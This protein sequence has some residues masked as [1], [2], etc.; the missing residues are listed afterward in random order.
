[1]PDEQPNFDVIWPSNEVMPLTSGQIKAL[2]KDADSWVNFLAM[3]L[4]KRS[5]AAMRIYEPG[6]KE[7]EIIKVIRRGRKAPPYASLV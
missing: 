7:P 5:F 3:L 6:K 4:G 2:V 1:M